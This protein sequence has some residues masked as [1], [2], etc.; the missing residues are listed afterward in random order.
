MNTASRIPLI[1]VV[2]VCYNSAEFIEQCILS[3]IGQSFPDYEYI[4]IDGGSK[5]GTVEIIEKHLGKID[6]FHSKPDRGIADAFNQGLL[7][8]KGR[9]IVFLNSDD[10]FAHVS[11]LSDIAKELQVHE[12]AD[13]VYG[14]IQIIRREINVVPMSEPIG[15]VWSWPAF[16][17]YSTIPH[18]A[19]FTQRSFFE[20]VGN[21][22]LDFRNA[23][24]Y[25]LYLR[26]GH[27]LKA[28]HVPQ[29]ISY[30]RDGGVSKNDAYRSYRESRDAQLKNDALNKLSAYGYYMG[31]ILR[32]F[33]KSTLLPFLDNRHSTPAH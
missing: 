21:F 29:L 9:W 12:E 17:K 23:L 18:P 27:A 7:Q 5:D 33:I 22:D 16:R 19:A 6:Y 2:T 31:Y 14:Q 8:S 3:V 11:V 15:D 30:M 25:E 24:D 10:C 13:L 20:R 32:N 1:S 4:V 26:A 28:V